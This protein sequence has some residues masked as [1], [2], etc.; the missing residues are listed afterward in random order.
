[1]L[2]AMWL[3]VVLVTPKRLSEGKTGVGSQTV[4]RIDMLFRWQLI[5]TDFSGFKEGDFFR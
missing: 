5:K 2:L 3:A 1:M 4:E